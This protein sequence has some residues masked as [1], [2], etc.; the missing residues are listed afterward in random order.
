[1]RQIAEDETGA[2]KGAVT[3]PSS[4]SA[5]KAEWETE[6]RS[7]KLRW[8][9]YSW[10]MS[11][12]Y[13]HSQVWEL[14]ALCRRLGLSQGFPL[15]IVIMKLCDPD[16]VA[17]CLGASV[18][19][20]LMKGALCECGGPSRLLRCWDSASLPEFLNHQCEPFKNDR[21]FQQEQCLFR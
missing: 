19:P 7:V 2:Q 15:T 9:S 14:N 8:G 21:F 5:R 20:S 12:S 16:K 4:H 10:T 3:C 18:S 1:M 13:W 6:T 11:Q 17:G